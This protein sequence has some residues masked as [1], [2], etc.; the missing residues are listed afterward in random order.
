[1]RKS[2]MFVMIGLLMLGTSGNVWAGN[3]V[4]A[5][6]V[7]TN[8]TG[9]VQTDEISDGAVTNSKI[10]VGAVTATNIA[11]GAVTTALIANGA[12]TDSKISGTITGAKLGAYT[13]WL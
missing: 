12:I 8:P 13:Q 7:C 3:V 6:L 5:D 2:L 11:G 9:C 4:A 1:M 10:A